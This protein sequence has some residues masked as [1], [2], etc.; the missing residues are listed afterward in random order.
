M[1][2]FKLNNIFNQTSFAAA[3]LYSIIATAGLFYVNLGGAFL[4]AFVDGLGVQR[5]VA[6]F[7]VSA[8][9]FYNNGFWS[10]KFDGHKFGCND[11]VWIPFM[12]GFGGITFAFFPNKMSY[13]YFSDEYIYSW[14]DAVFGKKANVIPPKPDI[15]GIHTS[16]LQPNL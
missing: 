13:Y 10:R 16:S 3:I 2:T 8:D 1:S 15:K 9:I 4:S 14:E 12:S 11:D 7:I 5:D 6:G